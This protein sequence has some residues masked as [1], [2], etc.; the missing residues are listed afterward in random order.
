MFFDDV[1]KRIRDGVIMQNSIKENKIQGSDA[2]NEMNQ[3]KNEVI[4]L[5]S[6]RVQLLER[7]KDAERAK[8][9]AERMLKET[10]EELMNLKV[11]EDEK[12]KDLISELDAEKSK[13][14][15][16]LNK[17][18]S[19]MES[20]LKNETKLKKAVLDGQE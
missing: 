13:N 19:A 4:E 14:G 11:A 1:V 12:V 8:H 17:L 15:Q 2:A 10:K 16:I 18:N 7:V 5:Q 6:V 3:Y 9:A 20:Y